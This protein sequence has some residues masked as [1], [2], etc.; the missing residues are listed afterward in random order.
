MQV[1]RSLDGLPTR[2]SSASKLTIHFT[3]TSVAKPKE[4]SQKTY[5]RLCLNVGLLI[6]A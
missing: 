5:K 3:C 4:V 6:E 2:S 1:V